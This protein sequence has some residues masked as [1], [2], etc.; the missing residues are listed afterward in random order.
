VSTAADDLRF[1]R[2]IEGLCA[3]GVRPVFELLREFAAE[4]LLR[5]PLEAKLDDYL[6]RLDRQR[7]ALTGGDQMPLPP[8]RLVRQH[9]MKPRGPPK[10]TAG[11]GE[12]PAA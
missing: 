1:A 9:T 3:L 4:R 12:E 11:P 10:K 7:L 8:L 6:V 5:Q 2:K